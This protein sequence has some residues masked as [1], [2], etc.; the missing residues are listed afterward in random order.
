M[1]GAIIHLAATCGMLTV[2]LTFIAA[3]LLRLVA[4][5]PTNLLT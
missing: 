5:L 3:S 4:H 2:R 1:Y